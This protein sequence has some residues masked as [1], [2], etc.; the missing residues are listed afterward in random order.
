MG[1]DN[2]KPAPPPPSPKEMKKQ[3]MRSIDRMCREFARDKNK[4]NMDNKR[5]MRDLEKMVKNKE[6]KSSQKIIAQNL[7]K[8]RQFL[9]KYDNMEAKMK[10]VKIQI[11]QVSTTEAMIDVMKGMA[12]ILGQSNAQI[13]MGNINNVIQDF[14]MKMEQQEGLQEMME[15]AFEDDDEIEDDAVDDL[16]DQVENKMGGGGG[17]QKNKVSETQSDDFS[18]MIDD[19]KK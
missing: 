12:G 14:Q 2:S 9:A 18:A 15:D 10:S 17:G 13:N 5:I 3:M 7:I 8:N 4:I 1:Q 19:L 11:Q 16:L 6:P